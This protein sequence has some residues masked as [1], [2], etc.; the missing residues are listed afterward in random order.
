M[1]EL[2][3]STV[4]G[5]LEIVGGVVLAV[6]GCRAGVLDG[7]SLGEVWATLSVLGGIVALVVPGVLLI[8]GMHPARWLGQLLPLGAL[9]LYVTLLLRR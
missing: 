6:A 8:R 9:V 2:R 3:A 1:K 7:S 4:L 5:W